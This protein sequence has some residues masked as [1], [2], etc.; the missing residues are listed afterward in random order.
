MLDHI[1]FKFQKPKD[2]VNFKFMDIKRKYT[3]SSYPC[4]LHS[5]DEKWWSNV[6]VN[7]FELVVI[8][9]LA[10]AKYIVSVAR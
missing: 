8:C 1:S 4:D 7:V 3:A 2:F 5:T 10:S 6:N 9:N